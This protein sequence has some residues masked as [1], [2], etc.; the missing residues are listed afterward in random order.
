M[1]EA[2]KALQGA[3]DL[4]TKLYDTEKATIDEDALKTALAAAVVDAAGNGF[5]YTARV[6]IGHLQAVLLG[7]KTHDEQQ[8]AD[9]AAR[10][11]L[12]SIGCDIE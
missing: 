8:R 5:A 7:S 3:I 2:A 6:A 1:S 9:T 12:A 10:D 11:W 4:L